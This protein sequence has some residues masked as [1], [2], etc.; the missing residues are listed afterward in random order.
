MG[1]WARRVVDY[2]RTVGVINVLLW[3]LPTGIFGAPQRQE[4]G[5]RERVAAIKAEKRRMGGIRGGARAVGGVWHAESNQKGDSR[6]CVE[7]GGASRLDRQMQDT[8]DRGE[9][10][11]SNV[12][13]RQGVD[14]VPS[15]GASPMGGLVYGGRGDALAVGGWWSV[16]RGNLR[17][18][19]GMKN[20]QLEW[21]VAS[22]S[23]HI[24]LTNRHHRSAAYLLF[25]GH[26][27]LDARCLLGGRTDGWMW[28]SVYLVNGIWHLQDNRIV[29]VEVMRCA[30]GVYTPPYAPCV[31]NTGGS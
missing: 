11:R 26:M 13:Q 3:L 22:V 4:G 31:R 6:V 10:Q 27:Y 15:P 16:R 20:S 28:V 1:G 12:D 9:E 24:A 29:C 30:W 25:H 21:S 19:G 7:M 17:R 8:R 2:N 18:G 14:S 5:C 23:V